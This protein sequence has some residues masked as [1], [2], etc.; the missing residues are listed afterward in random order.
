MATIYYVAKT[1]NNVNPGTEA[2]PKLTI[3]AGAGLLSAGDTLLIKTGTYVESLVNVFP[4]GTSWSNPVTIAAFP[5]DT[6]TV[7]GPVGALR[8]IEIFNDDRAYIVIDGLIIDGIDTGQN[9]GT[10]SGAGGECIKLTAGAAGT[11]PHHIRVQNT[12]IKN[13]PNV[14]ITVG[15]SATGTS[16]WNEFFN[17]YFHDNAWINVN[18]SSSGHGYNIYMQGSNNLVDDVLCVDSGSYGLV[19]FNGSTGEANDNTIRN[20]TILRSGIHETDRG[21]GIQVAGGTGALLYNNVIYDGSND[22]GIQ[23]WSPSE[24]YN[25]TIVN[26]VGYA[27]NFKR[28]SAADSS[29]VRNNIFWGN[30]TNGIN[31]SP[32]I[33]SNNTSTEPNFLDQANDDFHLTAASTVAINQGFDLSAFFTTDLDGN[34]RDANFD[35]GAYEYGVVGTA[36]TNVHAASYTITDDS[37]TALTA[38]TAISVTS[39]SGDVVQ[40]DLTSRNSLCV[41]AATASGAAVVAAGG[42]TV[43][44]ED[45]SDLDA[46]G[47]SIVDEGAAHGPSVWSASTGVMIQ[48]SQIF[49]NDADLTLPKLGTYAWWTAGTSWTNYHVS[50]DLSSTDNDTMGVMFR[51][52]DTNNYY[53]FSWNTQ[54][55]YRQLVKVVAGVWTLLAEDT[56]VYTAGQTYTVVI[57]ALGTTVEVR[58]DGSPIFGG[59]VTESDLTSGTVALYC[60]ANGPTNFDNV[61]VTDPAV[62]NYALVIT[63]IEADVI[64]TTES[65]TAQMDT[66]ETSE[67]I[68]FVSYDDG[69]LSDAT[70]FTV[71][72]PPEPPNVAPVV[73]L[74]GASPGT[75]VTTDFF[76]QTPVLIAPISTIS[77]ADTANLTALTVTLV[78]RPDGDSVETLSLNATATVAATGLTVSYT[79]ATGVLSVTGSALVVDYRTILRGI[80]YTN[81][82]APPT[83]TN[84]SITVIVN[85]GTDPSV[86]RTV[87]LTVTD[88]NQAPVNTVPASAT[89]E[90]DVTLAMTGPYLIS[91]TDADG[92]LATTQLTVIH[93]TVTVILSGAATISAGANGS[94]TLTISGTETDINATLASLT[95]DAPLGYT[96]LDALTVLSTDSGAPVLSDTDAISITVTATPGEGFVVTGT[97]RRFYGYQD[98]L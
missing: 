79:E 20:S 56:V 37:T 65:V 73:D 88:T 60:W 72:A 57:Q 90:K 68:D 48:T 81:T 46:V 39:G 83:E 23:L 5:G 24:I 55:T 6:V 76:E 1:G 94:A 51:Y 86:T 92:D 67:I 16:D 15:S 29:E 58:I 7:K 64:A 19:I 4:G 54:R 62:G 75:D 95:Y 30:S 12:E 22:G 27:I 84:R 14:G 93:G 91:V 74:N 44:D 41:L 18:P 78:A 10:T 96:G 53:R 31:L 8:V 87:T 66:G 3:N 21:A 35:I 63:G 33:A 2:L 32:G 80:V 59:A 69:A 77:D 50:V 85:D 17:I 11:F 26:N 25:N 49:N 70:A 36:P 71:E 9:I 38:G 82:S 98:R 13:A 97:R 42:A 43:L 34:T 61:L 47:W 89:T 28:Q 45:F 52:Q 40:V